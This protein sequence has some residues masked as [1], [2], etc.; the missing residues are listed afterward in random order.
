MR[1]CRED[2]VLTD[3][4]M[5]WEDILPPPTPSTNHT[6]P[7]TEVPTLYAPKSDDITNEP[8]IFKRWC[9]EQVLSLQFFSQYF[10][11]GQAL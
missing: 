6:R 10:S 9:A 8:E 7:Y 5:A 11:V 4:D 1:V 3:H 2:V